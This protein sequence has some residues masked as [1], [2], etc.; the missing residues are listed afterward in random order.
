MIF[1]VPVLSID[2]KVFGECVLIARYLGK[3]YGFAG[4]T[5][6]EQ[7]KC[8]GLVYAFKDYHKSKSSKWQ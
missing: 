8:D 6:L 5:E 3:I 2:G 7:L 1:L 4:A